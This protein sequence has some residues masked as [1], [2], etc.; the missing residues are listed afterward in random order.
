M[1]RNVDID[2]HVL[3]VNYKTNKQINENTEIFRVI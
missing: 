2:L 3:P 1:N